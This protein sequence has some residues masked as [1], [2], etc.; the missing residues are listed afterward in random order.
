MTDFEIYKENVINLG[1]DAL[2]S[3]IDTKPRLRTSTLNK[4]FIVEYARKGENYSSTNKIRLMVVG[5]VAGAFGKSEDG[6]FA[7]HHLSTLI[8]NNG[9]WEI[10]KEQIKSCFEEYYEKD[11]MDWIHHERDNV[12]GRRHVDSKPFFRFAKMVYLELT[13]QDQDFE[14]Y[15]NICNSNIYKVLYPVGGNPTWSVLERQEKT[16]VKIMKLEFE[17]FK[18]T[19]ILVMDGDEESCCWCNKIKEDLRRYAENTGAKICF[20]KRPEVNKSDELMKTVKRD[21]NIK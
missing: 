18:P 1:E 2:K 6:K 20:C 21:F 4:N 10:D 8:N 5:R 13:G 9:N 15:K 7:K 3:I 11:N 14:W 12:K 16:M 19:H 17:F